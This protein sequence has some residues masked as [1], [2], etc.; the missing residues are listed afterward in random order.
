MLSKILLESNSTEIWNLS[1]NLSSTREDFLLEIIQLK[2]IK[3][4]ETCNFQEY[5]VS[6]S[7]KA[8]KYKLQTL[9]FGFHKKSDIKI[10][11]ITKKGD[12]SKIFIIINN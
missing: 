3:K 2:K 6:L 11:K 7:K 10:K 9:T 1:D 12:Y 5:K 8:K 4:Y